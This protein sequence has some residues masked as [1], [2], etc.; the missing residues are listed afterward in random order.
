MSRLENLLGQPGGEPE[1]PSQEHPDSSWRA[2]A[3]GQSRHAR[4]TGQI[5]PPLDDR[6][7]ERAWAVLG[8]VCR[9]ALLDLTPALVLVSSAE[10]R[11]CQVLAALAQTVFDFARQSG[12]EGERL[13]AL[14]RVRFTLEQSLEGEPVGQPIYLGM[15]SEENRRAWDREALD[16]LLDAAVEQA[17]RG[18]PESIGELERRTERLAR[19]AH[20]AL[21]GETPSP[22]LVAGGAAVVRVRGLTG[23]G[24]GLRRGIAALP[25]DE[26][27]AAGD[28]ERVLDRA[29]VAAA[30]EAESRRIRPRLEAARRELASVRTEFRAAYDFLFLGSL[31]L[32]DQIDRLGWRVVESPPRLSLGLRLWLL[33]RARL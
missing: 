16:Q 27:P 21:V 14:N 25:V 8:E 19:A 32:L 29:T 9:N 24:E 3:L 31:T 20:A 26:L 33:L 13:A 7:P 2:D 11:R 6:R 10:R 12:V 15:A 18:R 5:R 22:P 30:V 28:P 23:L 17:T 4:L 1:A